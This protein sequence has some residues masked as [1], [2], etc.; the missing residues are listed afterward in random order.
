M[1]LNKLFKGHTDSEWL[2]F[3]EKSV[4]EQEKLQEREEMSDDPFVKL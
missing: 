2:A 4:V 3:M 1:S